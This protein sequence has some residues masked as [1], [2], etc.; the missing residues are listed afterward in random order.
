[1]LADRAYDKLLFDKSPHSID[2]LIETYHNSP[3][4]ETLR[5]LCIQLLG[6]KQTPK[7][8]ECLLTALEDPSVSVRREACLSLEE[9]RSPK[10]LEP[11]KK[12]FTDPNPDVRKTAKESYRTLKAKR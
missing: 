3:R 4:D 6:F 12:L 11:I 8:L 5:Y 9:L 2:A 10:A 1:M 7:A